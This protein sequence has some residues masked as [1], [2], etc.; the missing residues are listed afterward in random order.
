MRIQNYEEVKDQIRTF[1]PQYL[2]QQGVSKLNS[3]RCFNPKHQD[4]RPS[5]G[6]LADQTHYHCM[7]CGMTGDIFDACH[8]MEGKSNSGHAFVTDMDNTR[9][10]F[11]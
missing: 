3:F 8:F 1:L 9:T 11:G 6:I 7:G 5:A 2:E 4:S 10:I